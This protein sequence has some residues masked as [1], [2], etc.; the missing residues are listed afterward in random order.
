MSIVKLNKSEL[1]KRV[2]ESTNSAN[3]QIV[4]D[5]VNG[6]LEEIGSA[7]VAGEQVD[8]PGFGSFSRKLRNERN[9]R[10]PQTGETMVI[11][12]KWAPNFKVGK[13]LKDRVANCGASTKAE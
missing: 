13:D 4:S 5:I 3:R 6:L 2:Q 10:N 1:I 9:G 8:L 12:A 7:V 11:P